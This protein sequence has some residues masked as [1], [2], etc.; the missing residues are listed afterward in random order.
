M[1]GPKSDASSE[2][3]ASSDATDA[4][5]SESATGDASSADADAKTEEDAKTAEATRAEFASK[6]C[7]KIIFND[8]RKRFESIS[9]FLYLSE[10]RPGLG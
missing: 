9:N 6:V 1:G 8:V 5:K 3:E 7:D 10:P 2:K 4:A